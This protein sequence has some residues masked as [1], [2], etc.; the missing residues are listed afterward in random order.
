MKTSPA[1]PHA[2]I[3]TL[4][5]ITSSISSITNWLPLN[6]TPFLIFHR[7]HIRI[8]DTTFQNFLSFFFILPPSHHNGI[9]HLR[10]HHFITP[11]QINQTFGQWRRT[12]LIDSGSSL[13]NRH[14]MLAFAFKTPILW[15]NMDVLILPSQANQQKN[16][17]FGHIPHTNSEML[18]LGPL[19]S[20]FHF[21]IEGTEK[22][23]DEV[24]DHWLCAEK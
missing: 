23:P 15:R 22:N 5:L 20:T 21:Q 14:K 4:V 2:Q 3:A 11:D 17:T 7:D 1:A 16:F 19:A 9:A 8:R 13:Q 12:W 6:S 18:R 24:A 10:S